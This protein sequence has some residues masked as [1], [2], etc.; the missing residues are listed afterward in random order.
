[1]VVITDVNS[2][3]GSLLALKLI[4]SGEKVLGINGS[5]TQ[6]ASLISEG[7]E[8][9]VGD[10]SDPV[11]LSSTLKEAQT[12]FLI[13][14]MHTH[15]ENYSRYFIN[16]GSSVMKSVKN[17]KVRNLF[18]VSV[19]GAE[20]REEAGLLSGYG[21]L[22]EILGIVEP[23]NSAIFRPGYFMDHM[24]SKIAMIRTKD[25]I[26][27]VIDGNTPIYFSD[28]RD[29]VMQ[30]SDIYLNNEY[31]G[32]SKIELYSDKL[33]L[34]TACKI[35]AESIGIPELPFVQLS[36]QEYRNHLL[37]QGTSIPFANAYVEMAH[38]ISRGVMKPSLIDTS[39]PNCPTRFSQFVQDVFVPAYKC[40]EQSV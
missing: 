27:D 16:I 33:S 12:L 9:A 7:M 31:F 15:K 3:T 24:L 34:R 6:M 2:R 32:R 17:S 37:E 28:I 13:V 36:D 21:D 18:L 11:F 1:M 5:R 4:K 38:A 22:E 29:T 14:P 40:G 20:Q 19:M 25:M 30:I 8:G 39:V 10:I 23:Q 35:I 26:G